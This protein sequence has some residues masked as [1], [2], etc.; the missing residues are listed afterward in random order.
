VKINYDPKKNE[1][2]IR[3]RDLSFD[4]A[5]DLDF[6][7]A[8][9]FLR[10]GAEVRRIVVGYLDKRLHVLVYQYRD[11]GLWVISF[12]KASTKEAKRYGK[13]KTTD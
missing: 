2:N 6:A 7:T 10:E 12:R 5:A 9:Y 1:K 3:E 8:S 13:A 4:R 11:G